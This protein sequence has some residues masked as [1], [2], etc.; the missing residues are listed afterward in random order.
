MLVSARD[1]PPLA[2]FA[3]RAR[4]ACGLGALRRQGLAI[5]LSGHVGDKRVK[6]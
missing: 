5:D 4:S 2:R 6:G 3:E 1:Q